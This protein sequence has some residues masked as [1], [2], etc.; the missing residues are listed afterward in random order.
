MKLGILGLHIIKYFESWRPSLYLDTGGVPTI[1]WGHKIR[2]GD[3]AQWRDPS[4]EMSDQEGMQTLVAD[5]KEAQAALVRV[6]GEELVEKLNQNQYD[7]L[8][9]FIFNIGE[10]TLLEQGKNTCD[11]IRA[12]DHMRV[13][14]MLLKWDKDN[15][16]RQPGLVARRTIESWL[17]SAPPIVPSYTISVGALDPTV[18]KD[19]ESAPKGS[20]IILLAPA[21]G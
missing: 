7:A 17:Y 10:G 8:V 9:S 16:V 21:G 15:G 12:L 18:L 4:Y 6:F 3:P 5:I 19:L 11:A 20:Q 1:G 13:M 2:K 14:Q